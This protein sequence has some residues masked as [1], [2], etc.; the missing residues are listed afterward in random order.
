[1]NP[2]IFRAFCRSEGIPDPVAEY[3]F[4]PGRKWRADYAWPAGKLL[5]EV[6][7]GVW[8]GGRHNRSDGFQKDISKYNTASCMGFRIIRV[9]PA[10][11]LKV[12]T[13][14]MIRICLGLPQPA[15]ADGPPA[16]SE[17]KPVSGQGAVHP[18]A[19]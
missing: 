10:N 12:S 5:L 15:C 9:I 8:Q 4:C 19:S 3:S 17:A 14:E 6:E 1:M 2:L 13:I 7:G 18:G 11:L 16:G